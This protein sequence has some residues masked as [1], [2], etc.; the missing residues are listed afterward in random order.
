MNHLAYPF[1]QQLAPTERVH[2]DVQFKT[3][4]EPGMGPQNAG[5][6]GYTFTSGMSA[7]LPRG[8]ASESS[9]LVD[10]LSGSRATLDMQMA[11]GRERELVNFFPSPSTLDLTVVATSAEALLHHAVIQYRP[12]TS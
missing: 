11:G 5:D 1:T 8:A 4:R 12:Y 10:P 3:T 9:T 2:G 6:A 7:E